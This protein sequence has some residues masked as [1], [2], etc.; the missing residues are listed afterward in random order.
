MNFREWLLKNF[1]V[2]KLQKKDI[3]PEDIMNVSTLVNEYKKYIG[4]AQVMTVKVMNELLSENA[5]LGY[6]LLKD[7][8][9]KKV[10][11]TLCVAGIEFKE[12]EPAV[13]EDDANAD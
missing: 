3:Q 12:I 2:Y 1:N 5:D 7:N 11:Y 8:Y 4:D 13:V 6:I 10:R 9:I